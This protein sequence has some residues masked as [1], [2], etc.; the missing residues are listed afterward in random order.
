MKK[1]ENVVT[2]LT[3]A[4][5]LIAI[6]MFVFLFYNALRY[7]WVNL[8]VDE[9]YLSLTKDSVPQNILWLVAVAA[10]LYGLGRL[11]DGKLKRLNMNVFAVVV[12]LIC[13]GISIYWVFASLTRPRFDQDYICLYA[14]QFN[15][16]V[17]GALHKGQYLAQCQH[18]L[19][20]VTVLRALYKMFGQGNYVAYQIF[21]AVCVFVLVFAGYRIVMLVGGG[22][23]RAGCYYLLLML[24]CAPMYGYVPYVYGEIASTAL[25]MFSGW[26]LL[27]I[28][29]KFK[30]HKLIFL[31]LGMG[32][33]VQ[34][35]QNTLIVVVAFAIV[36]FLKCITDFGR[37]TIAVLGA[38]AI[39]VAGF[40]MMIAY[41]YAPLIAD[42]VENMPMILYV[43][44]GT[45][46]IDEHAGWFD[47]SNFDTFEQTGYDAGAASELGWERIEEFAE[48]CKENPS[49]MV[50]FYW[51]K[52]SAQWIAP[53]YQ[54]LAMT[55]GFLG[56]PTGIAEKIYYGRLGDGIN[57][58]MNIYQLFVYGSVLY[59]L[60]ARWKRCGRI[61]NHV[62]LI[63]VLGGFFF[64]VIWEAKARYV[65]PYFMMMLPYAA[66]GAEQVVTDAACAV[67]KCVIMK[68]NR[69]KGEN[70]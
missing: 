70:K 46:D 41:I 66:M 53:M 40:Q 44:M 69:D 62:L 6:V 35:R 63:A 51:R 32:L 45:S 19:G 29:H 27:S 48:Y 55:A 14:E 58:V 25:V 13:T 31:A 26:M 68:K 36:L 37:Q 23:R 50:D 61:E 38:V 2:F 49:Y 7:T 59:L 24:L 57:D 8:D 20:I 28:C 21:S 64:S 22:N 10:V 16:G 67:K 34:I 47:K 4:Y 39:G 43:A 1:R 9:E 15:L 11:I 60:I 65:F 17:C 56:E 18:Q 33:A 5:M 12:A 42:D 30:W 3:R 52:L 54:C